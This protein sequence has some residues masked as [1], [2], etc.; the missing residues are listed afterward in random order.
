MTVL[1]YCQIFD[2]HFFRNHMMVLISYF[3]SI[4]ATTFSLGMLFISDDHSYILR[5]MVVG[6]SRKHPTNEG[7]LYIKKTSFSKNAFRGFQI[8]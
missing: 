2:T 5:Y 6:E 1:K 3:S 4:Y 8:T 7:E